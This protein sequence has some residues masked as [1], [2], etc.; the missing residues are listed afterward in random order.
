MKRYPGSLRIVIVM[1][2][3][4][5]TMAVVFAAT[6]DS[7]INYTPD[8]RLPWGGSID[9]VEVMLNVLYKPDVPLKI[10]ESQLPNIYAMCVIDEDGYAHGSHMVFTFEEEKLM[11]YRAK[12]DEKAL[13]GVIAS[14]KRNYDGGGKGTVSSRNRTFWIFEKDFKKGGWNELYIVHDKILKKVRVQSRFVKQ[15]Q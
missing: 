5:L 6:P 10:C 4:L 14:A 12:F 1:L 7:K 2:S 3:M 8:A 11:G 15:S 9:E 13:K